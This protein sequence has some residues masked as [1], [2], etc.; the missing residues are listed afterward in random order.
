MKFQTEFENSLRHEEPY[1][2]LRQLAL[3]FAA[4]GQ[5]QQQVYETFEQFRAHLREANREQDEDLIMD[6]MDCICGYCSPQN[7][8]F[9]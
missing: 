5:T 7:R 1:N 6:V 9:D 4:Q 8:L 3:H 2:Q